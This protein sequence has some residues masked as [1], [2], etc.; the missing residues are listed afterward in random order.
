[1]SISYSFASP[2]IMDFSGL[3][4]ASNNGITGAQPGWNVSGIMDNIAAAK[5]LVIETN[6]VGDNAGGFGGIHLIYQGN[7][8][9]NTITVGWTDAGLNGGWTGYPRGNGIVSIA[10][11]LKVALGANY[12]NF[13]QCNGWARFILAYYGTG[14]AF[15]ALAL[16]GWDGSTISSA[17]SAVRLA[18]DFPAPAGATSLPNSM[19]FIWDGSVNDIGGTPPPPDP[20]IL[21]NV[22]FATSGWGYTYDKSTHTVTY[23]SDWTGCGWWFGGKDFSAYNEVVVNFEPV[24][25]GIQVIIEYNGGANNGGTSSSAWA[26]PGASSISAVLTG[27]KSNITQIYIQSSKAGQLKLISAYADQNAVNVTG[28][29]LD[30]ATLTL[31]LGKTYQLTATVAPDNATDK[32]VTWS[33]DDESIATVNGSGLVTAVSAGTATITVTTEDGGKT[34]ACTVTVPIPVTGVTLDQTTATLALGANLQ[35][36][37]TVAPADAANQNVTWS[38]SDPTVATVSATGLVTS[39]AVGQTNITVT[40]EDGGQSATCA[41]TVVIPVTNVTLY[42]PAASMTVGDILQLTAT[43]SPANATNNAVTWSSSDET[44]ATV[45]STGLIT[46]VGVGNATITI[47][48]EDGGYTATCD[49]TV[50]PATVIV[51]VTGITLD[52]TAAALYVGDVLQLTATF[53]PAN[54]TD[55]AVTWSSDNATVATVSSTGLVTAVAAGTAKITVTTDDGGHTATC[56]LTITLKSNIENVSVETSAYAIGNLLHVKSPIA[57]KVQVYSISGVLLQNLQKV[58]GEATY[59]INQA[60]GTA[61]IVKGGSGWVKKLIN[62]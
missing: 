48:T 45:S 15:T 4:D 20:L 60:K 38:S 56:T 13:L 2:V 5:Y 18:V 32:K 37:E 10:I 53:D 62:N 40:P 16:N 17:G 36:T 31:A 55:K 51:P 21:E 27:D 23:N 41:V 46:A 11:D 29:S 52:K 33:S 22:N 61:L 34:A 24:T 12:D 47:I 57:E 58:E 59:P 44:V 14:G 3:S 30:K 1:M 35:L 50:A 43:I 28:V 26:D 54:A 39:K 42:P 49:V 25:W 8:S 7:S 19:G 9:D 6:G